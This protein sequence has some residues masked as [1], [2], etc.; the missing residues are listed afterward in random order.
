MISVI[1][2]MRRVVRGLDMK[3]VL[4][5]IL[6]LRYFP[7]NQLLVR[8]AQVMPLYFTRRKLKGNIHLVICHHI[9]QSEINPFVSL[10]MFAKLTLQ[11]STRLDVKSISSLR[12]CAAKNITQILFK[13]LRAACI[14]TKR[15]CSNKSS[16]AFREGDQLTKI[17]KAFKS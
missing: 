8:S 16:K 14:T 11:S 4:Y 3:K 5:I 2:K 17:I 13:T 6:R 15:R 12:S 9:V 10:Q 7:Q 1:F